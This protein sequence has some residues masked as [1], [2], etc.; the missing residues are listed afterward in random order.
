ME[1][2][3]FITGPC[4]SG[5][6]KFAVKIA[7]ENFKNVVFIATG[8]EIDDEM[9]ERIEKHKKTRPKEWKTVEEDIDIENFIES[10]ND[11]IIDCITTW[12]TNLMLK[13]YG[14]KE[15]INKVKNLIIKIRKEKCCAII[16]S[17]EVGW[18]IVPENKIARDFRDIIG[19]VHQLI[20]ENSDYVYLI[21][22]GIPL[23]LKGEK[24]GVF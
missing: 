18:G 13:N 4:R 14:E 2:I 11:Y 12:I 3:I 8:K 10:G 7:K 15:I 19:K 16:V 5:K 17:N 22:S 6:S 9:K 24:N 1:N 21:V 20:S 23:K